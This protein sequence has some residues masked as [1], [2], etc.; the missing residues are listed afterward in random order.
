MEVIRGIDGDFSPRKCVITV[1]TFDGLHLGHRK[2]LDRLKTVAT[3]KGLCTT[4]VTFDP[5]PKVVVNPDVGRKLG[6]LTSLDE[7]IALLEASGIDRLVV[8]PFDSRFSQTRYETFV[9]T[10]LLEKL[11]AQ[12]VIVGHD[13]GFGKNREGNYEK[14]EEL[15]RNH[16]FSVEQIGHFDYEG[17]IVSSTLIRRLLEAGEVKKAGAYLGHTYTLTGMVVKGNN[18]GKKYN[19]PTANLEI[20]DPHKLIPATGVYAVDVVFEGHIFKGMM[21]IGYKPTFGSEKQTIETHIIDF[22]G[23]LYHKV[24][25]VRLKQRL[26]DEKKFASVEDLLAQLE[27]DKKYSL[28]I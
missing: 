3:E 5:H 9:T 4:V 27:I 13:H 20:T 10:V 2:I 28:M 17:Q 8:I 7:K 14:L 12:V 24:L 26:R 16:H 6:L 25:T 19:F 11:G 21:N 1:G 15:S 23:D 22:D 18:I